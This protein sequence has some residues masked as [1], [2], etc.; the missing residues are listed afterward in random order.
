MLKKVLIANRGEIAVRIIR[1]AR[2][3][4][5]RTVAVVLGGR[6]RA[7][8]SQVRRR[9]GARSA[10]AR[11]R[12]AICGST[13]SSP[14]P[15][16][17]GADG[18]HPGYGFLAENADFAEAVR[19]GRHHVHRPLARRHAHAWATRRRPRRIA[20][21]A[22]VPAV[23][24]YD[25]DSQDAE[26]ARRKRPQRIGFPV[27]IKAVAG[28]GGRGMRLVEREADFAAALDSAQ[29][30][31]QAAFGDAPRAAR[32]GD[33]TAA[34]HRGAGVRR[35]P[36]QRGASV[37]ARLLAAAA[38]PEGDRGG[39]CAGHVGRS[40]APRS[41]EAAVALRQSRQLR[42]RRHRRVPGRG[43]RCSRPTRPGTSSR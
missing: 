39:A 7:P 5:L 25:G 30:E 21:E 14:P 8:R 4:G 34:P 12:K 35:Q 17:T 40:C 28:G 6:P 27:I 9:G 19:Q 26:G 13:A 1:T 29:R 23:P 38:P 18:I 31:A 20:A 10:R 37:R 22:G 15:S 41:R 32:E 2:R 11:P 3:L 36:R 33:S 43:R 24:G 42:G 16:E